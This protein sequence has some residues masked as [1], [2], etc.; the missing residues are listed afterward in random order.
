M[1]FDSKF[2]EGTTFYF[3]IPKE[4]SFFYLKKLKE[5]S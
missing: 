5:V 1:T 3:T 2:G 4:R